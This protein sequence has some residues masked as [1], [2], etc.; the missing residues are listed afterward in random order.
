[1]NPIW[2]A[3]FVKG[4]GLVQPQNQWVF[5]PPLGPGW[6]PQWPLAQKDDLRDIK[7][8][9][10]ASGIPTNQRIHLRLM[11]PDF[12]GLKNPTYTVLGCPAGSD[13]NDP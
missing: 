10:E 5:S 9:V 12:R 1:M 8:K 13:R 3:Y 2:R 6:A 4:V 7:L 11:N